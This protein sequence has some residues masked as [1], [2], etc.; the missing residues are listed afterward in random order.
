[1]QKIFIFKTIKLL[2]NIFD[3]QQLVHL[4]MHLKMQKKQMQL[5]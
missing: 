3:F 5:F 2:I 4:I 1:M